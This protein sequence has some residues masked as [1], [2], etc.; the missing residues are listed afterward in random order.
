MNRQKTSVLTE[1]SSKWESLYGE[2]LVKFKELIRLKIQVLKKVDK[3]WIM[4]ND[5]QHNKTLKNAKNF[6]KILLDLDTYYKH[7]IEIKDDFSPIFNDSRFNDIIIGENDAPFDVLVNL[8]EELK[9]EF[10]NIK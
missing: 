8:S 10:P 1:L 7:M 2:E 6:Y 9:S 5:Y 4:F 3:Y